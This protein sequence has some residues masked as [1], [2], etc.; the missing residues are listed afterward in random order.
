MLFRSLR[1]QDRITRIESESTINMDL[2]EA[3]SKMRGAPGSSVTITVDRDGWDS[4]RD[5]TIVRDRIK[6]AR[7]KGELL[8]GGIA[9]VAIP[10]FHEQVDAQLEET[11][12]R[13]S[14]EA[15]PAGLKGLVLDLRENPGGYL[16]QAIA[17]SDR[18]LDHGTIVSTVE[19]D[20]KNREQRNAKES[21][22]EPDY[23]MAVLTS[24]NSASA[25]EIV[26]GALKNDERAVII[27]ER[28]FGKGSV[29]NLYSFSDGSR[30]KLTV[31][32]YLT[33]GD[34][35][36]QNVGIPPDIELEGAVLLPARDRKSTRLN[37]SHSSVSR[38][39]S[40]A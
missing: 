29:Q 12:G 3:V 32:R 9:W 24:G 31:A 15:G 16:H 18:F 33:P 40:S 1:A 19:R 14:R 2:D 26:A 5:Y 34:H 11:L 10:S 8:D 39:P 36:I 6:P 17:V 22:T 7:V 25:A 35:S 27:G 37:S 28:T 30:L 38:M 21:G 20:G 23:P 13:L 4:P